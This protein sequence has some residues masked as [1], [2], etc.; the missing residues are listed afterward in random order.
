M[1]LIGNISN[2]KVEF[3]FKVTSLKKIKLGPD[4]CCAFVCTAKGEKKRKEKKKQS[5][6]EIAGE[7][8]ER[9]KPDTLASCVGPFFRN[10]R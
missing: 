9:K 1:L 6:G 10:I 7:G 8:T 5:C 3:M 2:V 4:V